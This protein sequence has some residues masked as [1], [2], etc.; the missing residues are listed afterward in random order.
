MPFSPSSAQKNR[1]LTTILIYA[2]LLS[3]LAGTSLVN[4]ATANPVY[5]KPDYNEFTMYS[6]LQNQTY[7]LCNLTLEFTV[8]T[9][10]NHAYCYTL[11]GS[12]EYLTGPIWNDFLKV[13][14]ELIG[15]VVISDDSP[16][17]GY[18]PFPPYTE[19]TWNCSATLP[20]LSEGKHN[21]TIYTGLDKVN[22]H[23]AYYPLLT[24][25]FAVSSPPSVTVL[26]LESKTYGTADVPLDFAVS[27]PFSR[28]AYSLDGQANVTVTGNTTLTG[29]SSGQHSLTVYAW[30]TLGSTGTSETITFTVEPFPT[31]LVAARQRQPLQSQAY[32][33]TSENGNIKPAPNSSFTILH[34][35]STK[36]RKKRNHAAAL[37]KGAIV[38]SEH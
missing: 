15:Q 38:F 6:P 11:D 28:A 31:A 1:I 34:T 30:D 35:L 3:A 22:V 16:A 20:Q 37:Y 2:L 12:G 23:A 29:L 26:S 27:K 4:L 7:N 36:K 10:A 17:P 9:N 8:K 19:Y 24:V 32:S 14:Q 5:T 13:K 25:Y 21:L 18:P 33:C